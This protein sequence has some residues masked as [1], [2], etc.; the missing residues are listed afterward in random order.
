[1]EDRQS[2]R[3]DDAIFSS[4]IGT[5]AHTYMLFGQNDNE[6]STGR[7]QDRLEPRVGIH[8]SQLPDFFFT[9]KYR[10]HGL[11]SAFPTTLHAVFLSLL[12]RIPASPCPGIELDIPWRH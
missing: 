11:S 6:P 9:C 10:D 4:N 5:G 2:G 1:M 7:G 3:W 12:Y 8:V